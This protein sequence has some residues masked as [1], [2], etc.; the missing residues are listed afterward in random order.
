MGETA[1]VSVRAATGI[2]ENATRLV[3]IVAQTWIVT[4]ATITCGPKHRNQSTALYE[5]VGGNI[6][7]SSRHDFGEIYEC[8][9]EKRKGAE[10][11]CGERAPESTLHYNHNSSQQFACFQEIRKP[12]G[13]LTSVCARE[14]QFQVRSRRD[15][16]GIL[17]RTSE[18]EG[19]LGSW[20]GRRLFDLKNDLESRM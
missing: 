3:C 7:R 10:V 2:L 4:I 6:H 5:V 13:S 1:L 9:M 14:C 19:R 12:S 18:H 11:V 15:Q 17:R 20:C 8:G 16:G